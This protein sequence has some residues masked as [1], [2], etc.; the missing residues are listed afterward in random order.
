MKKTRFLFVASFVS[1]VL[2][3]MSPTLSAQGN[4]EFS[5]HYGSWGLNLLK[6]AIDSAASSVLKD[7]MI[8]SIKKNH[9][10]VIQ[11]SA[12]SSASFDSGGHNFG[13][14]FRWYPAGQDG[15]FSLGLAVEKTSMRVSMNGTAD[16]SV[17]FTDNGIVKSAGFNGQGSG[18]FMIAPLSFHFSFRW[19]ILPSARIH[20]FIT[21]GLGI[22]PGSY[23]DDGTLTYSVQGDLH[24]PDGTTEHD[25]DSG[26]K[27]LK[28]VRKEADDK[29][30]QEG[31]SSDI[32][33]WFIPFVQLNIGLKAKITDNIHI[34]ID[35]GILDG[36]ILRAGIA[37]RL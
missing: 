10:D 5:F 12:D 35:G 25:A 29:A 8:D 15:S 32:P 28:D 37:V 1:A 21:F 23:L 17:H 2:L 31:K 30:L 16:L 14:E 18:E 4:F 27:T 33:F 36:F 26:T 6:G 3:L 13:F 24:N 11:D 20:P 34:I 7:Q 19:D 9:P 22:S